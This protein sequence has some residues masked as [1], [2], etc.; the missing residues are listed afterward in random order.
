MPVSLDE[1]K[2]LVAANAPVLRLHPN[3]IYMPCSADFFMEHAE[4]LVGQT[5]EASKVPLAQAGVLPVTP[6]CA[7][8]IAH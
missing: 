2:R 5:P 6:F 8:L 4:L 1:L 3:D 7:M